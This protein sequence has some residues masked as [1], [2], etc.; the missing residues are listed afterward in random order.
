MKDPVYS[1]LRG[2]RNE[3]QRTTH[4]RFPSVEHLGEVAIQTVIRLPAVVR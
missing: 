2:A 1:N 3:S 4:T